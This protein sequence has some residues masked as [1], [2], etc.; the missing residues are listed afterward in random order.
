MVISECLVNKPNNVTRTTT[1]LHCLR[2]YRLPNTF[3][4]TL[5]HLIAATI[6]KEYRTSTPPNT[7]FLK[8]EKKLRLRRFAY[9]CT[10]DK[11]HRPEPG[12]PGPQPLI[13]L[14]DLCHLLLASEALASECARTAIKLSS[15]TCEHA[16]HYFTVT[17]KCAH[18]MVSMIP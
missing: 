10:A 12:A 5:S 15:A 6:Y 17:F 18:L 14:S 11:W 13:L 2:F 8:W 16:W 4:C 1:V 7:L 9:D 3:P